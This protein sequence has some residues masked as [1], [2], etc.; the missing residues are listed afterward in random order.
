MGTGLERKPGGSTL[1]QTASDGGSPGVPGKR[2]LTEQVDHES[3]AP[4]ASTRVQR[5]ADGDVSPAAHDR[6]AA[7]STS[8]GAG[9]P[10]PLQGRLEGALGVDLSGVRVHTGGESAAAAQAVGARAYTSGQDIHF[11]A[12][13]FDPASGDGERLIAHEVAHTVQQRGGAGA[14]QNK[15]E[16]SAP[17]DALER[18]A[19]TFADQFAA[20][21]G[22]TGQVTTGAAT[23][24][25]TVHRDGPATATWSPVKFYEADGLVPAND[26]YQAGNNLDM[27]VLTLSPL[28]KAGIPMAAQIS[29]QAS[30]KK[31]MV[32]ADGP[33][34]PAEATDLTNLNTV[35]VM[36]YRAGVQQMKKALDDSLAKYKEPEGLAEA[37][38]EVQ[39]LLHEGFTHDESLLGKAQHASEQ[40]H[41]AAEN[42]HHLIE[43]AEVARKQVTMINQWFV[44]PSE[45]SFDAILEKGGEFLRIANVVHAALQAVWATASAISAHGDGG[46]S[47]AQKGAA[48]IEAGHAGAAAGLAAGAFVGISGAASM[49]LIWSS[50]VGPQMNMALHAL[51]RL[52]DIAAKGAHKN[53]EEWW[54]EQAEKGGGPPLIPK[55]YLAQNWF[56]GGQETLNYMWAVFQGA[57]PERAPASVTKFFYDNRK[58]LNE[59]GGGGELDTEWHAFSPNEVKNLK[60]WVVE[61]KTE[62]WGMLYGNLPHP[63]G[64]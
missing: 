50:L 22:A 62:V 12:G 30:G 48:A 28:V 25:S 26:H 27:I 2:T 16:I 21:A 6:L 15:L 11:G 19:D 54:R 42:V 1:R 40:L 20:G 18:E 29:K 56:P 13:R 24:T 51:E 61:H 31:S 34:T 14:H 45:N 8:T 7:A 47:T 53:V 5:K 3:V 33:L 9:L 64:A 38:E 41:I 59:G 57:P 44:E 17:G 10:A 4:A 63:G 23:G 60:E 43:M 39:E 35:A 55:E 36:A 58:K 49:G 46:K 32:A 52:D 37:E